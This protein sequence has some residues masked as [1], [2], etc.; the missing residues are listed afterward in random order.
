MEAESNNWT[1]V[2][3]WFDSTNVPTQFWTTV[4][5]QGLLNLRITTM[6][7]STQRGAKRA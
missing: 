4:R 7:M 1:E 5:E 3:N 2:V 6:T